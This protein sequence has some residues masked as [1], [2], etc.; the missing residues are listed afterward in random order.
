MPKLLLTGFGPFGSIEVNPSQLIAE[1]LHGETFGP[2]EVV[3]HV[4]PVVFGED[5]VLVESLVAEH[6]P[7][8]VLS[9]GVSARH[10]TLRLETLGRNLR[11]APEGPR[12]I[13]DEGPAVTLATVA[14]AEILGRIT[15]VTAPIELSDHAG[16]YLC[17]H[18]LYT[19]LR[20]G[21]RS[22]GRFRAGFLHIPK[23]IEHHPG[24]DLSRPLA[25]IEQGVRAV[26][27]E[28]GAWFDRSRGESWT[29]RSSRE[30]NPAADSRLT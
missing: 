10:G 17:N 1:R 3:S 18:V 15:G 20:L 22:G 16:D 9:L 13:L 23:A 25:E 8:I 19:T 5:A 12:P 4:L 21:E 2:L 30:N 6:D 11:Q 14:F 27:T 26:L 7:V 29:M 24:D 28:I